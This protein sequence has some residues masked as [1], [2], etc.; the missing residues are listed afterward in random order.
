[1]GRLNGRDDGVVRSEAYAA[2]ARSMAAWTTIA[3]GSDDAVH[4]VSIT[5]CCNR[6][7][8]RTHQNCSIGGESVCGAAAEEHPAPG[9]RC[10]GSAACESSQSISHCNA[11]NCSRKQQQSLLLYAVIVP[12]VAA[13]FGL[14]LF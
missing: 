11:Q 12:H 2:A 4:Q 13:I 8:I 6:Y 14:N 1:V 9:G 3:A 10:A 7:N 5:Q